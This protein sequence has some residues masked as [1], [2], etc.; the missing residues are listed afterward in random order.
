MGQRVHRMG[1]LGL[2]FA[3]VA[4]LVAIVSGP[5]GAAPG[6]TVFNLC[7]TNGTATMGDGTSVDVWGF[8]ETTSCSAGLLSDAAPAV[9]STDVPDGTTITVNLTNALAEPVNVYSSG[10]LST[11]DYTGVAPAATKAY[12][13][14]AS[15]GTFLFES[16]LQAKHVLLGLVGVIDIRPSGVSLYGQPHD[17]RS[18]QVLSEIDPALNANPAGFNL[19]DYNPTYFLLNGFSH[20]GQ[21]GPKANDIDVDAGDTLQVSYVNAGTS[22]ST[23]AS[24]SVRQNVIAV[25]GD[26]TPAPQDSSTVFIAA[27]Q[28]T[29]VLIGVVGSVGDRHALMNRNIRAHNTA[30]SSFYGSQLVF[31]A[32]QGAGPVPPTSLYISTVRNA[33]GI[34]GDEDILAWNGVELTK[35]WD[36]TV[37]GLASNADIKAFHVVDDDNILMSFAAN[38]GTSIPDGVGPVDDSDIVLWNSTSGWSLV[39]EGALFG[40]TTNS[41]D[42]DAMFLLPDDSLVISTIGNIT[43]T[44]PNTN[45]RT[46]RDEDLTRFTPTSGSFLGGGVTAGDW[47][48]WYF[49]GSDVG[50]R[51]GGNAEDV[52]AAARGT[53][54]LLSTNGTAVATGGFTWADEDIASCAGHTPGNNTTCFFSKPFD[55]TDA[56]LLA[57]NDV[58]GISLP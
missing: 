34:G 14:T 29:D 57:N 12:T 35:Y 9:L 41:E 42:I 3:L 18:I 21:L 46:R 26:P 56:G 1:M 40:L 50:L 4:S 36:G 55:G 11:P 15:E 2:A 48:A 58:D 10:L 19:L 24:M 32:V 17:S 45:V 33:P 37:E 51:D 54:L 7:A 53:T 23:M 43:F 6:Q 22:N 28:T 13:L 30:A 38:A 47:D 44:L 39:F 5:A 25:N 16:N 49:D 8:V 52:T 27:G 20:D 31:I